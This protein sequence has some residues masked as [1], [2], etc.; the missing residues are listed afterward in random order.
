MNYL[1]ILILVIIFAALCFVI[2]L[3]YGIALNVESIENENAN[4]NVYCFECEIE[5]PVKLK[6]GG[7]YCSNCGLHH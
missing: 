4:D 3:L 7:M 5:M 6:N 1:L 2:G